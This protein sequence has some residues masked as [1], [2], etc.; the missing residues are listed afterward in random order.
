VNATRDLHRKQ[1]A[2]WGWHDTRRKSADQATSPCRIN[3]KGRCDRADCCCH[4]QATRV[5]ANRRSDTAKQI[6][7]KARRKQGTAVS[8][9]TKDVIQFF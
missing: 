7:T 9:S 3:V 4:W 1:L 8:G 5:S 6:R 2:L